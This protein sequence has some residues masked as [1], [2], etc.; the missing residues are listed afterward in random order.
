MVAAADVGNELVNRLLRTELVIPPYPAV[1]AAL[2]RLP[3]DR[4]TLADVAKIVGTDGALAANVLRSATSAALSNTGAPPTL[5]AAV[6]KLGVDELVRIS[7]ALSLGAVMTASGPLADLRRDEWRRS[8]ISAV[9]CRELAARRGLDPSQAFLAVLLHDFGALVA[10]TGLEITSGL[11]ILRAAVW[12]DIVR[13]VH[14]DVGALV[15]ARWKLPPPIANVIAHH[16]QPEGHGELAQLVAIVDRIIAILD[17][18][19]TTGIAALVEIG[20]LSS[21]ERY[22]IGAL[23][24]QLADA[25]ERFETSAKQTPSAIEPVVP[26]EDAWQVAF[27][28]TTKKHQTCH[29]IAM[30][31]NH[32]ALRMAVALSPGW[33]TDIQIGPDAVDV[34]VNV[35]TCT[36]RDGMFIVEVKP[37]GLGGAGKQAWFALIEQTRPRVT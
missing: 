10:L 28:V 9:F 18:A 37:F 29:A 12:R 2:Q 30:G 23:I 22:Q 13:E 25:M 24:P 27:D 33:L 31:P 17:R 26:F 11:P 15:A 21:A 5:E 6:F 4:T 34:L 19:P 20:S 14:V 36:P 7:I 3:R 16:H 35:V 8:L 1:A 32:L